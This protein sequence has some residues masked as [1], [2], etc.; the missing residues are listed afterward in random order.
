MSAKNCKGWN[1]VGVGAI[2]FS[3]RLSVKHDYHT[4]ISSAFKE[5]RV[6]RQPWQ[7]IITGEIQGD[8]RDMRGRRDWKGDKR[9]RCGVRRMPS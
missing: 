2:P 3:T 7:A 9:T 6:S 1:R 8:D 4:G 5:P